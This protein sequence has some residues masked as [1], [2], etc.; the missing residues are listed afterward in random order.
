MPTSATT[1]TVELTAN[2]HYWAGTPAIRSVHLLVT[3]DGASP[4]QA[5]Q[6]GKVDLTSIGSYDASWVA[7]DK[8]LGP[9]LRKGSLPLPRVLRVRHEEAA[10]RRRAR[11]E[12]VRV[13]GR[14]AS[15]G[16]PG[17]GRVGG[18]GD[19]H[20]AAGRPREVHAGLRPRLRSRGRPR[21]PRGGRLSR[22]RRLPGG[23]A[24]HDGQRLRCRG[25][26][27]A[28][29]EPRRHDRDRERETSRS[30][31]IGSS[32][33]TPSPSGRWTGSPTTPR[34]P[35]RSG[36]SSARTSRTTT[37]GGARRPTTP[38]WTRGAP[39]TDPAAAAAAFDRAEGI[40]RDEAP[41]VPF[42]YSTSWWLSRDGLL[43]AGENGLGFI[44]LAGLDWANK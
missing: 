40:V 27:P 41:V 1:S 13:G 15:P 4:V 18:A 11:P 32:R 25:R 19:E 21:A 36:S 39:R 38:R 2:D 22:R 8:D 20:G 29:G 35:R 26:R 5:F 33:T 42:Y 24:D 12:G 9:A 34:G 6:D 17:N 7:F 14:L 30:T 23:H 16:G 44:R 3:L 10:V 43:G 28:E 31:S 37:A